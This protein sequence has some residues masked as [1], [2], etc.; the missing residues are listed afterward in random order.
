M[1]ERRQVEMAAMMTMTAMTAMMTAVVGV[2]EA[3]EERREE[4]R[5]AAGGSRGEGK[6]EGEGRGASGD[7]VLPAA[8]LTGSNNCSLLGLGWLKHDRLSAS[9]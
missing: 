7:S 6:G 5:E 1:G 8:L 4:G 2:Q 9:A 3:A